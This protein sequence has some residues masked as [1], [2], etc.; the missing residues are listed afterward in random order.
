MYENDPRIRPDRYCPPGHRFLIQF[1]DLPDAQAVQAECLRIF[2]RRFPSLYIVPAVIEVADGANH[3]RMH[4]HNGFRVYVPA[5]GRH[6]YS[7]QRQA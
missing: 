1:I 5:G 6:G 4:R 2:G 3:R 7:S